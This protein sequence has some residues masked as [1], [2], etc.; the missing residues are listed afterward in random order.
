MTTDFYYWPWVSDIE[1]YVFVIVSP[2]VCFFGEKLR[3][4]SIL[5]LFYGIACYCVDLYAVNHASNDT[6]GTQLGVKWTVWCIVMVV[7]CIVA[8]CLLKLSVILAGAGAAVLLANIAYQM[9]LSAGFPDFLYARL[10]V[11]VIFAII[12]ALIAL[13]SLKWALRLFTPILGAFLFV[14]AVDHFGKFMGWWSSQPFFPRPRPNGQFFS[15]PQDFPWGDR[16]HSATLLS[17]WIFFALA[18]ILV[19]WHFARRRARKEVIIHEKQ[20]QPA[21]DGGQVHEKPKKGEMQE[22]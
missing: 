5:A 11:L 12:G 14:A 2:F 15:D 8:C 13:A 21:P 22:V 16:K 4:L 6:E 1:A 7:G 17:L 9:I 18:G 20:A 10:L 19:Q 3:G